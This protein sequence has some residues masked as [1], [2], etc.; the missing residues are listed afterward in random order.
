MKKKC[1]VL[2]YRLISKPRHGKIHTFWWE[3][4][5]NTSC[6]PAI[7]VKDTF[8]ARTGIH[9]L[10]EYIGPTQ[11]DK[12]FALKYR[13]GLAVQLCISELKYIE[14]IVSLKSLQSYISCVIS[15]C[16]IFNSFL[17]VSSIWF[18]CVIIIIQH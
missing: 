7:P 3:E 1:N 6:A 17:I 11:Y 16:K 13:G 5:N 14:V 10:Y 12:Q 9:F 8:N 4:C 15:I 18:H 2:K